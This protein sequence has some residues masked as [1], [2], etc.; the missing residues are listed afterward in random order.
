[1]GNGFVKYLK[2]TEKLQPFIYDVFLSDSPNSA[3]S[4]PPKQ[5]KL[6]QKRGSM[7]MRQRNQNDGFPSQDL[8]S[9]NVC[10]SGLH[11]D[12]L[13]CLYSHSFDERANIPQIKEKINGGEFIRFKSFP[14]CWKADDMQNRSPACPQ[15]TFFSSLFWTILENI[16]TVVSVALAT[17]KIININ[18]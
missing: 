14:H 16:S 17:Q 6:Y 12:E 4:T 7:E 8:D 9:S 10:E 13:Y 15:V 2:A 1:M 3:D 11:D 5:R 18:F